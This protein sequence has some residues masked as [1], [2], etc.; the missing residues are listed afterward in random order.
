M[1]KTFAVILVI[2]LVI[3]AMISITIKAKQDDEKAVKKTNLEYQQYLGKKVY[4]TDV[5]TIINRA[6]ENNTQHNIQKDE[7]G[8][9]IDDGEYCIKV[10]LNMITVEKT[11]QMEQLYNA[12]LTEFVKNFNLIDFE[13]TKIEY[14]EKTG[15]ISKIVFNE[16]EEQN[17]Y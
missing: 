9:Y 7:K 11:Y 3:V 13:C 14:H 1:K 16:L 8:M 2:L 17:S 10:E 15:R 12:G 6:I 5:T 4:G